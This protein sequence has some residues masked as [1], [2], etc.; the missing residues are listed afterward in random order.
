MAKGKKGKRKYTVVYTG[1]RGLLNINK[2]TKTK[3][4][5]G[6]L[7]LISILLP[8]GLVMMTNPTLGYIIVIVCLV[9]GWTL[10]IWTGWLKRTCIH[11]IGYVLI[12]IMAIFL[13]VIVPSIG[14][15]SSTDKS[16]TN[17]TPQPI[18]T[19]IQDS[20]GST[21]VNVEETEGDVTIINTLTRTTP[22]SELT[23]ILMPADEPDP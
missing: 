1:K 21:V 2:V 23:G 11:Y 5:H 7:K 3:I 16:Q 20:P 15:D 10:L 6:G 9:A 22:E 12:A 4:I 18:T 19:N 17:I 8:V 13:P 14:A